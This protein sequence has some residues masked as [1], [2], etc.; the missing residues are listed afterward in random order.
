ME[1]TKDAMQHIVNHMLPKTD[2]AIVIDK[3]L[4]MAKLDNAFQEL[5]E[6][7]GI[8]DE[9]LEEEMNEWFKENYD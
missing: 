7:K 8:S 5:E 3:I 1:I 4:L 9:K 6:G 2:V